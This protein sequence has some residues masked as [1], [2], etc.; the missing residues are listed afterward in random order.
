M[1]KIKIA[2]R[3]IIDS[4][5]SS[6]FEKKLFN[7]SFNEFCLQSQAYSEGGRLKTFQDLIN[8]NPKANSLHY[9]VG[10]SVGRYVA[11]L[12]NVIPGLRDSIGKPMAFENHEFQLLDSDISNKNAHK[13]AIIY[14][15]DWFELFAIAGNF[16]IVGNSLE[17]GAIS[18]L[19]IQL[20][21]NVSIVEWNKVKSEKQDFEVYDNEKQLG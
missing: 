1:I 21:E 2:Y 18:T 19:A 8:H 6:D 3:Q 16:L 7:D 5:S 13:I 9:K 17:D 12:R 15:S 14:T 11:E 4:S 20:R 10:F